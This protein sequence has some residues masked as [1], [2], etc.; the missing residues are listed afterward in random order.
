MAHE[1]DTYQVVATAGAGAVLAGTV[2][3][4]VDREVDRF[5][6]ELDVKRN[7]KYV[8]GIALGRFFDWYYGSGRQMDAI[9]KAD[10][11]AFKE[12][13]LYGDGERKKEKTV[14]LY[15]V[16]VRRFFAWIEDNKMGLNVAKG[17]KVS[18][19]RKDFVKQ[20][21]S[22]EECSR[23]LEAI[24]ADYKDRK[25][26]FRKKDIESA[27]DYAIVNLM[28]RTGLRTVEVS[29]ADYKDISE[30]KNSEGNNIRILWVQGKGHNEKDTFVPFGD[31]AYAPLAH[32]LELRGPLS[33]SSPLFVCHGTNS[34]GRRLSA[35]RIQ[36]ICKE[37]L[38]AIGLTGH[39]YSA[40]SLRHTCGV[41]IIKNGGTIF[42]VQTQLRHVNPATSEIYLKS[43][44]DEMKLD[45]APEHFIDKAF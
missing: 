13:L 39:E 27:R 42:D 28:L 17:V 21:L 22:A 8:Y 3:A 29:R 36:A 20:H 44:A 40:H 14:K 25:I 31:K 35:K 45:S 16:A 9:T 26:M 32:Y 6:S 2:R 23:L 33:P 7:T 15:L 34:E 41:Q 5:L 10:I 19:G 38:E 43:I 18:G 24:D 4:E 37:A 12:A 11:V 30:K 1:N